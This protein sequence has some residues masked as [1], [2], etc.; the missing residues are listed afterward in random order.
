MESDSYNST[1]RSI[2]NKLYLYD[3]DTENA[4]ADKKHTRLVIGAEYKGT[5]GYYPVD[6]EDTDA[7]KLIKIIRNKKYVFNINSADG[8][9]YADKETA[10]SQ[11]SVHIN[12]NIIEWDMT[13]GQMGA[14]GNYYLWTEKREA[15]L[16]RK[17]NSAVTIS[18]KSNI[19]SEAITM[20]FKTDL[21]GPATNIANGIRNNRFE[22]LF[23]NDADGYPAGLKITALG[24]YDKNSA[25]T[26]SD[27]I[28]LLS[29]RIRLE[30]QIHLY[31][32]GQNDWELDGDI[33]TDLGE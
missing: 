19:L 11:P 9:G 6:F 22:A 14:S 21:N 2:A 3:N 16:Y 13:E 15:V 18:M 1:N 30:I 8:P 28:V 20:A 7:D 5:K 32:Q 27:T 12:V 33:S 25:G 24:D 31:N 10:A 29:G 26:N 4:T 23:V 17:A